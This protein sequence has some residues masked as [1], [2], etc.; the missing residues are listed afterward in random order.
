[1]PQAVVAM[2]ESA[3][4]QTTPSRRKRRR[5]NRSVIG[6]ARVVAVVRGTS[7]PTYE[8]TWTAGKA[9]VILLC[10]RTPTITPNESACAERE[11]WL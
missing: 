11:S 6:F 1:M 4:V 2:L 8:G 10:G 5:S 7:A 3:V 9:H